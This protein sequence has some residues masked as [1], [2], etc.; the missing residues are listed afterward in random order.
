[1]M[2]AMF[3]TNFEKLAGI[4][5]KDEKDDPE[6]PYNYVASGEDQTYYIT[7][8]LRATLRQVLFHHFFSI[9]L[10]SIL[11]LVFSGP[12]LVLTARI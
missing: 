8:A 11:I 4:S 7:A 3:V 1:M 10:I 5:Y 12:L 2:L 9:H 6:A